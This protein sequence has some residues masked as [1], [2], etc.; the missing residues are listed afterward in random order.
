[1]RF[2][3]ELGTQENDLEEKVE[4]HIALVARSLRYTTLDPSPGQKYTQEN[5]LD[6]KVEQHI[7]LVAR[8]L[9]YTTLD[10]WLGQKYR[11]LSKLSA[12]AVIPFLIYAKSTSSRGPR[13]LEWDFEK[14]LK[15]STP[16]F[17]SVMNT[18]EAPSP[19]AEFN[20]PVSGSKS[21]V[22]VF[23][24]SGGFGEGVQRGP[25]DVRLMFAHSKKLSSGSSSFT[26]EPWYRVLSEGPKKYRQG[27]R[28]AI[29]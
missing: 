1:M 22:M 28:A 19:N 11:A 18:K 4:R 23:L 17:L 2:S 13:H 20:S 27:K 21:P 26:S 6:E 16:Q 5:D 24:H 15:I 29:S 10:P 7:A 8:S 3:L 25:K 14:F 9:Q 12:N